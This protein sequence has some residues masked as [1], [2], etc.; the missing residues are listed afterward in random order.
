MVGAAAALLASLAFAHPPHGGGF[1]GRP[2]PGSGWH[3]EARAAQPRFG[4]VNRGMNGGGMN[5]GGP[6]WGLRP[7]STPTYG[8]PYSGH[9]QYAGTPQY[10]GG[11]Y[12][13]YPGN[14][15]YRSISAN[16]G[17]MQ[18]PGQSD[19]AVRSGSIRADVARYNEERGGGGRPQPQPRMQDNGGGRSTFFSSF[20]RNN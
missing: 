12:G 13:R 2:G 6:R 14:S 20:Y 8:T 3:G 10:G 19:G 11:Q 9:P 4:G 5:G 7:M 1:G 18:R 16:S 17:G 15:P